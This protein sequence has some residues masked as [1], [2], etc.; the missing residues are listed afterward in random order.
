[1]CIA[2]ISTAHPDYKLILIDNRDEFVNRP[3]AIA[4]WWPE[5][6]SDV[7]GGR[8]LLREV[9]GTWL[10]ITKSGKIAV[11]TNYRED[12]PPNP[13][14]ISRGAIIRKFLTE[15]VG[16]IEEFVKTI[17]NTGIAR[18]AGGFSL[19][20]GH[21]GQKLAV[22]SNRAADQS[23]VP[24]IAG[25]VVQTVGLSNAA[26]LDRSWKKVTEGEDMM[27]HAIQASQKEAD[28]EDQLIQRFLKLL[29]HDSLLREAD[30][31]EGGLQTY[32]TQL[33]NTIF[34]PPLG[35]KIM[36]GLDEEGMRAARAAEKVQIFDG[37]TNYQP[38]QLGVD[39]IYA[40]QKQTVVLVRQDD[41]VRFVE[42]TLFDE[43]SKSL[44]RGA[45]DVD[46]EFMIEREQ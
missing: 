16:P 6:S 12:Q 36:D 26:F 27:L 1:M 41:S 42:R 25:G 9:Q 10:G 35:R 17:V 30:L 15:D 24:W 4:S 8:D 33:R 40:T 21:V 14:A 32:I 23:E 34:V 39:G 29:S 45:S 44:P 7:L 38:R 31:A 46:I 18:D 22:I 2:L 20:C 28:S 19:V 11:L 43:H 13:Q 5:P 3:T 37:E